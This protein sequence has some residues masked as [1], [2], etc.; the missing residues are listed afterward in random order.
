MGYTQQVGYLWKLC[1]YSNEYK[2]LY[3]DNNFSGP[4]T[5]HQLKTFPWTALTTSAH[6]IYS[7]RMIYKNP[8]IPGHI[9][10]D[11][12]CYHYITYGTRYFEG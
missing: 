6:S 12:G 2:V 7:G 5:H 8:G 4:S 9:C 11:D 3:Y 10:M 1:P